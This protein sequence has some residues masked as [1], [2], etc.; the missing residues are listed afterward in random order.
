MGV[1]VLAGGVEEEAATEEVEKSSQRGRIYHRNP[2]SVREEGG[3]GWKSKKGWVS[4]GRE[5]NYILI[6]QIRLGQGKKIS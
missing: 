3:R 1:T 4:G 6:G 5:S 2:A